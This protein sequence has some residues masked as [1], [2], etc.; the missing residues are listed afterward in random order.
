MH[1]RARLGKGRPSGTYHFSPPHAGG[2]QFFDSFGE[3]NRADC[4]DHELHCRIS[5]WG[6][7]LPNC[8]PECPFSVSGAVKTGIVTTAI[9]GDWVDG[10]AKA[11]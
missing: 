8:R 1:D 2:S 10:P 9:G 6:V 11:F 7:V 3:R 5:I 4:S